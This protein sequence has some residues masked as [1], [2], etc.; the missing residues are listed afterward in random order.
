MDIELNPVEL[1]VLGCLIEKE[2][3]TPD[4]YPLT[5]NSLVSAC[6]QKSNRFPVME[7]EQSTVE[8]TLY[9]LRMEHK[10]AIEVTSTGSR[11]AKYKHNM[12]DQW[13]FS[14][15]QIAILCEL[16]VRGPQTPGDLRAHCSRLH[17]LADSKEVEDLLHELI[18]EEDG[19]F[20]VQLPREP[21]K[22][23]R[24]W[25]HLFGGAPE[26]QEMLPEEHTST[27]LPT[28]QTRGERIEI[29]ELEV[30]DLRQDLDALKNAFDTF[31]SS[32]G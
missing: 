24:R 16:F 5:L 23:E 22:R 31:K 15:S 19:P 11:V 7:L 25:A 29:L 12:A 20:V 32:F 8:H 4:H 28:G 14:L 6:N 27:E 2:M 13:S 30:A 21:G 17:S 18:T 10:L 26:E 3:A 9:E 1:R